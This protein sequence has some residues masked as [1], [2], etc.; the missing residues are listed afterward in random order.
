MSPG[1]TY[2][3]SHPPIPADRCIKATSP[4]LHPRFP[5][6]QT[7]GSGGGCAPSQLQLNP[8]GRSV[9]GTEAQCVLWDGTCSP[10]RPCCV[11]QGWLMSAA[12]FTPSAAAALVGAP[13]CQK[14][15][16]GT[17]CISGG[18]F[19]SCCGP[20][21]PLLA[22]GSSGGV[23]QQDGVPPQAPQNAHG[24]RRGCAAPHCAAAS[25]ASSAAPGRKVGRG[26]GRWD[27]GQG[28]W[29]AAGQDLPQ[30]D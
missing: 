6:A 20:C 26:Q 3:T 7:G 30:R 18:G 27:K 11:L 23:G 19:S 25:S 5:A 24:W 10:E 13:L 28:M 22:L 15:R 16:G 21:R 8:Q 1:A 4:P 12:L 29:V 2:G 14:E 17:A 9:G